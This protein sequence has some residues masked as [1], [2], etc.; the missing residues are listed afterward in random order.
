[1]TVTY[2]ISLQ[3]NTA[4]SEEMVFNELYGLGSRYGNRYLEQLN[5]VSE[6]DIK[7]VANTYLDPAAQT[8]VVVG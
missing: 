8:L 2:E 6:T 7:R 4:Q 1:M 3:S 5:K